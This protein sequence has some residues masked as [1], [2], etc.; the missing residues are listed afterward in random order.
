MKNQSAIVAGSDGIRDGMIM[1]ALYGL[2]FY[3]QMNL[4]DKNPRLVV[5]GRK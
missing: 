5:L 2:P 4:M 1:A 3:L